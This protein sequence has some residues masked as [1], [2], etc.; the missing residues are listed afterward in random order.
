M[1]KRYTHIKSNIY[2]KWKHNDVNWVCIGEDMPIINPIIKTVGGGSEVEL[3]IQVSGA[4]Y[5][6]FKS[7]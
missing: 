4:K 6:I 3:T 5:F 7:C 2:I 1:S